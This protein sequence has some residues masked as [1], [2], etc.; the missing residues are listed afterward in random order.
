MTFAQKKVVKNHK[1]K[2]EPMVPCVNIVLNGCFIA[3]TNVKL[4]LIAKNIQ[5][6]IWAM[7]E[8]FTKSHNNLPPQLL[9]SYLK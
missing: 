7:S 1:G 9:L 6:T 4:S 3:V 8:N 5:L 2:L